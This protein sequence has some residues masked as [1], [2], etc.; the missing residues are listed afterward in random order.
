[1]MRSNQ[2][3]GKAVVKGATSLAR[4]GMWTTILATM[5][6]G[7]AGE[8]PPRIRATGVEVREQ[9]QAG[10]VLAITLEADNLTKTPLPLR[11]VTYSLYL[12][13][14]KVFEGERSAEATIQRF[15]SQRVVLP[16]A[17]VPTGKVQGRARYRVEGTMTYLVTGALAEALFDADVLR[18]SVSFVGEGEADL[19]APAL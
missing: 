7:C 15:G 13:G 10:V 5:L 4:I 16:A 18:P 3:E 12:D 19:D 17:F 6:G 2:L 9:T 14:E 11:E 1:M 8:P